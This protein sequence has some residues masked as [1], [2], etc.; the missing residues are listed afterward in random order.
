MPAPCPRC[1]A[2]K[3]ER[4]RAGVRYELAR[5]LGYELNQC[6]GCRRL[7]FLRRH[8][9]RRENVPANSAPATRRAGRSSA[10]EERAENRA[11]EGTP[12]TASIAGGAAQDASGPLVADR[13]TPHTHA[14]R[15]DSDGLSGCPRC[16][17]KRYRRSRRRWL[18]R[19]MGRAPMARCKA[20]G[21]RFALPQASS[22]KHRSKASGG[23]E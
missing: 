6:A 23:D 11:P 20:C 17:S 8:A 2:T 10:Q 12:V 21:Y 4:I 18:E 1:G 22:Q 3:T 13:E 14:R 9:R 5:L 15:N 19:V 16:G 7:R